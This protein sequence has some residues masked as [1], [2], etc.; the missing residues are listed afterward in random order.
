M[1]K[2]AIIER[3]SYPVE[4]LY[5][6]RYV[7]HSRTIYAVITNGAGL[8]VNTICLSANIFPAYAINDSC[9]SSAIVIVVVLVVVKVDVDVT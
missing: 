1:S 7:F 9:Y 3:E 8:P 6:S 5:C 4:D 2:R